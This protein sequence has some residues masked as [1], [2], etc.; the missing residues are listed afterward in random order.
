MKAQ[1][2]SG[3]VGVGRQE[4]HKA[5][6][7]LRPHETKP[8]P[9]RRHGATWETE[10]R[11]GAPEPMGSGDASWPRRAD[12]VSWLEIREKA[13]QVEAQVGAGLGGAGGRQPHGGRRKPE[14]WPDWTGEGRKHP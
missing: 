10:L 2:G 5:A 12:V 9:C 3:A 11:E 6:L 7:G 13:V 4:A 14:G 8:T 1:H